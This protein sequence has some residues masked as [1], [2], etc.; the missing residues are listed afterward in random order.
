MTPFWFIGLIQSIGMLL[1]LHVK[2]KDP[3][4][5]KSF[6]FGN[7][8]FSG[9]HFGAQGKCYFSDG[10]FCEILKTTLGIKTFY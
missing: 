5:T 7:G 8:F 1:K 2:R 10:S 6:S 9:G 4:V 3:K